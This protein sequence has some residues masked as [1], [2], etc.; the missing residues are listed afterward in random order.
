MGREQEI[1]R[2]TC[3]D[4]EDKLKIVREEKTDREREG[5]RR[6]EKRGGGM[7]M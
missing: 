3:R 5:K 6:G 2:K 1:E 7:G 4:E